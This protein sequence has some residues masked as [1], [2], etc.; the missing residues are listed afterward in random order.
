ML[1]G[2]KALLIYFDDKTYKCIIG[3]ELFHNVKIY[4]IIFSHYDENT[5]IFDTENFYESVKVGIKTNMH[6]CQDYDAT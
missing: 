3:N 5:G 4:P 6:F 2:N 1:V